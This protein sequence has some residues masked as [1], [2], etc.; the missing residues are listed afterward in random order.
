MAP[1]PAALVFSELA[2]PLP[3]ALSRPTAPR[4]AVPPMRA[5]RLKLFLVA[6]WLLAVYAVLAVMGVVSFCLM[7]AGV[8]RIPKIMIIY[9]G[10]CITLYNSTVAHLESE[11]QEFS[12]YF[13]IFIALFEYPYYEYPVFARIFQILSDNYTTAPPHRYTKTP[14]APFRKYKKCPPGLSGWTLSIALGY[15]P[16]R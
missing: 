6:S 12:R 11:N 5:R 3:Q 7:R 9:A 13:L 14:K 10:Y 4:A 16:R 8:S 15:S 1:A 2:L